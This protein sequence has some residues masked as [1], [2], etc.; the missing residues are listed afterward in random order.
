[1]TKRAPKALRHWDFD[2]RYSLG[3]RASSFVISPEVHGDR[4][5]LIRRQRAGEGPGLA[6]GRRRGADYLVGERAGGLVFQHAVLAWGQ[7]VEL[8]V[9]DHAHLH[10][11][12]VH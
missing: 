1:M 2:I 8:A 10:R 3:I 12:G 6:S 7:A 4:E 9:D 5:G 11:I